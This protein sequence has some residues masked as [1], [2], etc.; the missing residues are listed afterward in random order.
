MYSYNSYHKI[1][2]IFLVFG[3]AIFQFTSRDEDSFEYDNG[4]A[5][6]TGIQKNNLNHGTWTWYF[7]NGS[8][9][10]T[11]EFV[12]GEREG[13]WKRYDS[14]GN[15]VTESMYKDN[16]LNGLFTV[17]SVDGAVYEQLEYSKGIL[18]KKLTN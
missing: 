4:Q 13:L 7:P 5:K 14:I 10:L 8:T 9:Q 17:Y 12:Q 18:K 11:G 2:G 1:I 3:W 6:R 15:L 16:Q